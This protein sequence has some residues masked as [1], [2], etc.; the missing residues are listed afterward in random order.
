MNTPIPTMII[1]HDTDFN[2]DN[3]SAIEIPATAKI[4]VVIDKKFTLEIELTIKSAHGQTGKQNANDVSDT[5][6]NTGNFV[7]LEPINNPISEKLTKNITPNKVDTV[8]A[9][10]GLLSDIINCENKTNVT[11]KIRI[12]VYAT[13]SLN[14]I[15]TSIQFIV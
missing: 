9:T 5:Q 4:G 7:N 3:L 14:T 15:S 10:S 12:F 8:I 2:S 13:Y 1:F 6:P 11:A